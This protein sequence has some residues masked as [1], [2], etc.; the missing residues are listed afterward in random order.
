MI[1]NRAFYLIESAPIKDKIPSKRLSVEKIITYD[2]A[3]MVHKIIRKRC[4]EILKV[5][6]TRGTQNSK[7]ETRRIHNLQIPKQRLEL[8]KK[9]F[10]YVGAKVWNIPNAIRTVE[11]AHVFKHKMKP[12][13]WANEWTNTEIGYPLT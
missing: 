9:S 12:A 1:Q 6:F 8:S 2:R 13:S 7:Y 5:K 10:S 11:S 4:P 3:I